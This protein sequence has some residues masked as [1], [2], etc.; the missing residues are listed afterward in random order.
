[1]ARARQTMA[2]DEV[3]LK[4]LRKQ[5]EALPEKLRGKPVVTAL[6]KSLQP[7]KRAVV[8]VAK[9]SMDTRTI[10]RA[11]HIITGKY[12]RVNKSAPYVVLKYRDKDFSHA[13]HPRSVLCS[14]P[15]Q[16]EQ[17]RPPRGWGCISRGPYRW[18]EPEASAGRAAQ[19]QGL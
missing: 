5:I 16:L 10:D 1:M 17:N 12:A 15:D 18:P 4:E 7:T 6:K 13:P 8:R 2:V 3:A 9:S 11:H 19:T 14:G